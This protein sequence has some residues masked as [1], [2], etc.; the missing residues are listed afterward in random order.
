MTVSEHI[1]QIGIEGSPPAVRDDC[2]RLV[3]SDGVPVH[4]FRGDG[5]KDVG[6]RGYRDESGIDRA[7]R[8]SGYPDPFHLSWWN[9]T[10]SCAKSRKA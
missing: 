5:V 4:P 9:R 3:E 1:H 6:D 7:A 2:A 8:P 10:M